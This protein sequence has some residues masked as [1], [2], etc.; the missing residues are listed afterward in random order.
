MSYKQCY[1][2]FGFN[3]ICDFLARGAIIASQNNLFSMEPSW[4]IKWTLKFFVA[5][6]ISGGGARSGAVG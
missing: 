3:S 1:Q 5:T 4:L 2:N 6:K